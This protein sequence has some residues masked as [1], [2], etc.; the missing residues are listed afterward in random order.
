MADLKISRVTNP[1]EIF[2]VLPVVKSAWGMDDPSQLVKDI[3]TAMNFHGGLV[4]IAW[5][6]DKP[7]GMH[8][9]FPGRYNGRNYLYSHMT[10]I[11][12]AKKSSGI[13][14]SLK[15]KQREWA[16][17]NGY[18]LIVW[19]FDPLMALN[20]HFNFGK[21]GVIS[22]SYRRNFYGTMDDSLN[23]GLPTDRFIVEWWIKQKK[24]RH[25]PA[26]FVIDVGNAPEIDENLPDQLIVKIPADF[27]RIKAE[28]ISYASTIRLRSREVFE[29]LFSHGYAALDF[30]KE[31]PGY[32][33]AK[34]PDEEAHFGMRI[35]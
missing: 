21:L 25:D 9:S 24:A 33:F 5:D 13:G 11:V 26:R 14:Y 19:T 16:I 12:E 28:D 34:E 31:I 1:D 8:F 35:F 2:N 30:F 20:A 10:G 32:L 15:M 7:T 4:L 18:D 17:E 22:R 23:R 27:K 3:L 6:G 29:Y